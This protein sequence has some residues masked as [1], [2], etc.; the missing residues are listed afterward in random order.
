[1]KM[2]LSAVESIAP[3]LGKLSPWNLVSMFYKPQK[4]WQYIIDNSELVLVDSGAH[5]FQ[6]GKTVDWEVYTDKYAEF[7]QAVDSNKVLGYFEMDIDKRTSFEHVLKLRKKLEKVTDK[8]I[9]VW[10]KNRGWDDYVKCCKKYPIVA[11][12][13]FVKED[14]RRDQFGLF[15]RT[16]WKHGAKIHAL[17]MGDTRVMKK[18]PFNYTDSATWR[19]CQGFGHVYTPMGQMRTRV[20]QG[21]K[22]EATNMDKARLSY[23]NA[24]IMQQYFSEYWRHVDET[25]PWDAKRRRRTQ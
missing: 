9:P 11:I 2:F 14:I 8:I 18:F 7:I 16:A 6:K 19:N 5:S 23:E 21:G 22:E 4:H 24:K 15:I 1:M 17:G 10:H 25:A 12:S 20:S 3:D 13:G